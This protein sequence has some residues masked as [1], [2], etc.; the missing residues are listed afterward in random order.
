[1]KMKTQDEAIMW[2]FNARM[3]IQ[4]GG[5]VARIGFFG[6]EAAIA[7]LNAMLTRSAPSYE[8]HWYV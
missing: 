7:E 1:M 3:N 8:S 4:R 2:I 6:V 5:L